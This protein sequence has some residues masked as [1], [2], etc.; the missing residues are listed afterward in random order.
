ML[1]K[2]KNNEI[3]RILREYENREDQGDKEMAY[4]IK[5]LEEEVRDKDQKYHELMIEKDRRIRKES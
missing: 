4:R 1:E 2:E 5:R 3:N